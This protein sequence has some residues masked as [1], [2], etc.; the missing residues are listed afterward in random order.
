M[1]LL[2]GIFI[3]WRAP[4]FISITLQKQNKYKERFENHSQKVK[5]QQSIKQQY[6][7]SVSMDSN[8]N[9]N[10]NESISQKSISSNPSLLSRDFSFETIKAGE[11][12]LSFSSMLS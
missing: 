10:N 6:S 7:S 1:I 2:C 5:D 8:N 4:F 12:K 11:C 9:N 3:L